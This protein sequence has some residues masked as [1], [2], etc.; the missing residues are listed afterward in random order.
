MQNVKRQMSL[1]LRAAWCIFQRVLCIRTL[2]VVVFYFV[3]K[4]ESVFLYVFLFLRSFVSLVGWLVGWLLL[5]LLLLLL[6]FQY[7]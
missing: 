3:L 5:L 1:F 6:L 4:F 2:A 7:E